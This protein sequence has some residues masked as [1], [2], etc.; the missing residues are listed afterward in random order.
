MRKF[1]DVHCHLVPG[2]DDGAR[3]LNMSLSILK[4]EY[5]DGVRDII[6]TPHYR[7]GMFETDR[8]RVKEQ[9]ELLRNETQREWP[10]LNLILG[11]EYHASHEMVSRFD[12]EELY[13]LGG[14]N[15][16]LVEFSEAHD[17]RYMRNRINEVL[18]AGYRPIIAHMERYPICRSDQ[19]LV[20]FFKESGCLIQV[21]CDSVIGKEG[22]WVKRFVKKLM[23]EQMVDLIGTDAHNMDERSPHIKECAEY[24]DGVFGQEY[25]DTL[26]EK[27]PRKVIERI[28]AYHQ[29]RKTVRED[30]KPDKEAFVRRKVVIKEI[31][32]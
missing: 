17:S 20:R 8:A 27:N 29:N 19:E 9:F 12:A 28:Q 15:Y 31:E 16:V 6:M 2:V 32:L 14:S 5:A 11:C 13:R 24:L 25:T 30:H 10:D 3:D 4:K 23:K 22:F 18:Q 1:C 21:N 7:R 26:M